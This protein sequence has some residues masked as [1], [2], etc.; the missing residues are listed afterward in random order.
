M[1]IKLAKAPIRATGPAV[2]FVLDDRGGALVSITLSIKGFPPI[3]HEKTH[4]GP[5]KEPLT[6]PAG[7][8]ACKILVAA[9]KYGALNARYDTTV[10]ANGSLIASTKGDIP[11]AEESA[12][13]YEKFRLVVS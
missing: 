5:K 8:Y 3:E 11:K 13:E 7:T 2:E 10:T 6:M 9:F 4:R 12:M 1:K